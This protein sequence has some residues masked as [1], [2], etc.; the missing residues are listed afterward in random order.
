MRMIRGRIASHAR[1]E[2][3]TIDWPRII[4]GSLIAYYPETRSKSVVVTSL[5][6]AAG[7]REQLDNAVFW[8]IIRSAELWDTTGSCENTNDSLFDFIQSWE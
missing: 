1:N 7:W 2:E 3:R 4:L 5:L 6:P 8:N